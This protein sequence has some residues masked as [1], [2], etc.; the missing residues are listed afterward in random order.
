[1]SPNVGPGTVAPLQRRHPG[2][3]CWPTALSRLCCKILTGSLL[4]CIK[5]G[6]KSLSLRGSEAPVHI[7][8]GSCR[9]IQTA[10]SLV[11]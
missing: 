10:V 7:M 8:C 2:A 6:G 3:P 9:L 4:K 1:M 11:Q 5:Y